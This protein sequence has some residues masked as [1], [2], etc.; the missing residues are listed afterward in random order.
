MRTQPSVSSSML[1]V[2]FFTTRISCLT[3]FVS[4]PGQRLRR[5]I[6]PGAAFAAEL[7]V[8][9]G[10]AAIDLGEVVGGFVLAA[11]AGQEGGVAGQ[12]LQA[13]GRRP[14]APLVGGIRLGVA[15]PAPPARGPG[16][17]RWP[18]CGSPA[19]RAACRPAAG[20]QRRGQ[21]RSGRWPG[22]AAG[23]D[24]RRGCPASLRRRA[25]R[26]RRAG[27]ARRPAAA[28]RI[29]LCTVGLSSVAALAWRYS[30]PG[31]SASR[32]AMPI[33]LARV[34]PVRSGSTMAMK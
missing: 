14:A 23:P 17:G 34:P 11:D 28:R 33:R 20:L 19:R 31:S 9:P 5:Q 18:G 7:G 22:Q 1:M 2:T 32:A 30:R 15:T 12:R 16:P 21:A 10:D 24:R 26:P 3:K 4:S 27:R 29:R 25:A 8:G 6:A 13:R